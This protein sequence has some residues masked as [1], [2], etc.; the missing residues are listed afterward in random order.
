VTRLHRFTAWSATFALTI[1]L[2]SIPIQTSHGAVTC[3]APAPGS[4]RWDVKTLADHN[5]QRVMSTPRDVT[6]AML[7]DFAKAGPPKTLKL[8]K[9]TARIAPVEVTIF[10]VRVRL[11]QHKMEGDNDFHVVI[12]D[13]AEAPPDVPERVAK[14]TLDFSKLPATMVAEIP[15][16]GCAEGSIGLA[17]IRTVRQAYVAAYGQ[18]GRGK[19]HQ[20]VGLPVVTVTGVGFFDECGPSHDPTGHA[21]NCLELHPVLDISQ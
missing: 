3:A 20:V 9:K 8:A 1:A 6:F 5:A 14:T 2:V 21:P 15:D 13:P 19:P 11:I 7:I 16:P 17:Q 10:R 4:W 18:P 12:T